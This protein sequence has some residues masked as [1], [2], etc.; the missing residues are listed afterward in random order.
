MTVDHLIWPGSARVAF[1]FRPKFRVRN[2]GEVIA[3]TGSTDID[4]QQAIIHEE[5]SRKSEL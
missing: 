2:K 5:T 1:V 4:K 3:R